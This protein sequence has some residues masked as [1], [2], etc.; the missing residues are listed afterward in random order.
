MICE[1][2]KNQGSV[3]MLWEKVV[4]GEV[5]SGKAFLS[6]CPLR[7]ALKNLDMRADMSVK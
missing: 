5:R 3:L 7:L 4:K 6:R 2:G 1:L